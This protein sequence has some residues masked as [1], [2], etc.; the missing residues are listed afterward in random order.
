M[1]INKSYI[2]VYGVSINTDYHSRTLKIV[3]TLV[4]RNKAISISSFSEKAISIS[5]FSEYGSGRLHRQNF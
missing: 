2:D 5:S 4:N 3:Q 1:Y